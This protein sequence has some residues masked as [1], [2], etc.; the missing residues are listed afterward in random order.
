MPS[1][2]KVK[3]STRET[4]LLA[5]IPVDGS[6]INTKQIVAA[7]YGRDIPTNGRMIIT[8]RLSKIAHKLALMQDEPLRL[9]KSKRCGPA[10]IEYWLAKAS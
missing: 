1:S 2:R 10:P 8:D 7:Y 5:C 6:R 9:M 3:L 4:D